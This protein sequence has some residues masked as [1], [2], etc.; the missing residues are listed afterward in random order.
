MKC[1]IVITQNPADFIFSAGIRDDDF[2]TE[3]IEA[4]KISKIKSSE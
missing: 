2:S 3:S 1:V 4:V